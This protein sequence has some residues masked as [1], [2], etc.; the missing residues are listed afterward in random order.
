MPPERPLAPPAEPDLEQARLVFWVCAVA[1][2]GVFLVFYLDVYGELATTWDRYGSPLLGLVYAL[3]AACIHR[4]PRRLNATIIAA[5]VPTSVY[6]IGCLVMADQ[7][8]DSNGLYSMASNAQ[9]MPLFYIGVFVALRR[10]AATVCWLHY[11]GLLLTYLVLYGWPLNDNPID[12]HDPNEH[13]W[14][15]LLSAHPACIVALHYISALKGRIR[16]SERAHQAAKE[17]FLAMLSH[18][19]RTPLQSMLGS[20]DLLALRARSPAEQRAVERVHQAAAQLDAHL[21]DVTEYTRLENPE[22]PLQIGPVDLPALLADIVDT[23]SPQ[24]Q[25]KGLNLRSVWPADGPPDAAHH[26]ATDAARLRQILSN[27]VSNALKYTLQGEVML[28]AQLSETQPPTL[29]I[30][31]RDT[32]IGLPPEEVDRIFEPYVRLEDQRTREIDGSGLGLAIVQ[33]LAR[34]LHASLE[35]E[36]LLGEGSCFRLRL[37]AAAPP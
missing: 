1:S 32:G 18:E 28:Q 21:R 6:F 34:R 9:F 13:L 5:V 37:P 15:V 12:R 36:S 33:L 2:L 19:I 4:W 22:W 25:A 30:A 11:I 27:L 29:L 31:V 26:F 8:H 14:L 17:R 23:F 3:A 16:A 24:A 7:E 10:G 20:V 35:V